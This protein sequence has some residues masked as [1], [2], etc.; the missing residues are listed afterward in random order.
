MHLVFVLDLRFLVRRDEEFRAVR[1]RSLSTLADVIGISQ[2]CSN[3]DAHFLSIVI[4]GRTQCQVHL[5]PTPISALSEIRRAISSLVAHPP[6]AISDDENSALV[7]LAAVTAAADLCHKRSGVSHAVIISCLPIQEKLT[8]RLIGHACISQTAQMSLTIIVSHSEISVASFAT[9]SPSCFLHL[10]P[11]RSGIQLVALLQD[12][13][14]QRL[15]CD[16]RKVDL[17]L[18]DIRVSLLASPLRMSSTA[19]PFP[20][21]LVSMHKIINEHVDEASLG[22]SWVMTL[23]LSSEEC[24]A[25]SPQTVLFFAIAESV[26]QDHL[27]I[28]EGRVED[29]TFRVL[30]FSDPN[31]SLYCREIIPREQKRLCFPHSSYRAW[32]G[33]SGSAAVTSAVSSLAA[34]LSL[35][36]SQQTSFAAPPARTVQPSKVVRS[37]HEPKFSSIQGV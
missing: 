11:A 9:F 20:E 22:C 6:A 5:Q 12:L 34:S 7:T 30:M 33:S 18:G 23:N 21:Q 1:D 26:S 14:S 32:Y 31:G 8:A 29:K 19:L 2:N 15:L 24:A 36:Y 3:S 28:A 4:T 13:L 27:L 25:F 37:L 10:V 16:V 17:Q 35:N